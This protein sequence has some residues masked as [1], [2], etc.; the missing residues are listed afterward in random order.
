MQWLW[1][2]QNYIL[3]RRVTICDHYQQE[4]DWNQHPQNERLSSPLPNP[5]NH[6]SSL[7]TFLCYMRKKDTPCFIDGKGNRMET[8]SAIQRPGYC[9]LIAQRPW[10]GQGNSIQSALG[11]LSA[12]IYSTAYGLGPGTAALT[13]AS[14]LPMSA[15]PAT[16]SRKHLSWFTPFISYFLNKL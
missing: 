11:K 1:T 6:P 10:L 14:L 7:R 5:L 16:V 9:D 13:Q 12:T 3:H 2:Q 4:V 8:D 15:K